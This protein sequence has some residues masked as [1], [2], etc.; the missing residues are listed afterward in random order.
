MAGIQL[1]RSSSPGA[2][3]ANL[4]EGELAINTADGKLYAHVSGQV[5]VIG[6]V[7][8]IEDA[9]ADGGQYVRQDNGWQPAAAGGG[10][11]TLLASGNFPT[12]NA[13]Y[14]FPV[15]FTSEYSL[16]KLMMLNVTCDGSSNTQMELLASSDGATWQTGSF[17]YKYRFNDT[18]QSSSSITSN[19]LALTSNALGKSGAVCA[20]L[21]VFA[22]TAIA[23]TRIGMQVWHEDNSGNPEATLGHGIVR[24]AAPVLALKM[25][26][27]HAPFG[28]GEIR[29][30]G[31]R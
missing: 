25:R 1:R 3:P 8:F 24:A 17:D 15:T 12:G 9:P 26:L 4:Q 29:V 2:V 19:K 18:T 28:S 7:S 11:W 6:S 16:Y 14:V 31:I 10:D 23:P 27:T 21:T 5:V 22:P 13:E 30:Y 20:E